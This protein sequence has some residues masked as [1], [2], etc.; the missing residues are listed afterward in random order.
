MD[1]IMPP[2]LLISMTKKRMK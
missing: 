1:S 2:Y